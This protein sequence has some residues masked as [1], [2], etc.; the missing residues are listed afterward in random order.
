MGIGQ[1]TAFKHAHA[2]TEESKW[3]LRRNTWVKL[4]Q[5]ASRRIT[6][7]S[8]HFASGAT[9]FFVN[10]FKPGL[11]QENFTTHFQTRRN[12]VAMQF[13]RNRADRAYVGGNVLTG[14]PI[15]TGCGT[16]QHAVFIED[17]DS[18]AIKFQLATVDER[19]GT[20]QP[21]LNAFIEGKKAL[22]IEDVIKRQHRD[23]MAYL[24]K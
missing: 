17:T 6:W 1:F 4:T 7:V 9:R 5:R 11:G 13:Q 8:K 24:A 14:R 10:F 20:F 16:Y 22:L 12:I 21:I 3:S 18:Q 23:F 19:I 15:A 2:I